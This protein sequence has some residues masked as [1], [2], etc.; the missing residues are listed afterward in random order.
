MAS[1]GIGRPRRMEVIFILAFCI[2]LFLFNRSF[3]LNG[4]N[5]DE[6]SSEIMAFTPQVESVNDNVDL[7]E[8]PSGWIEPHK[9]DAVTIVIVLTAR[10]NFDKR[11]AIRETWAKDKSNVYFVIGDD[12][13]YPPDQRSNQLSCELDPA[14]GELPRIN[15]EYTEQLRLES[16]LILQEQQ[17]F[18]DFIWTPQ[19][20]NYQ[21]LPHKVK[22][23][24]T[25]II[26][27]FPTVQWI[28]KTDDDM[29][30]Q[31]DIAKYYLQSKNAT[32]Y[33]VVGHIV[34]SAKVHKKGKWAE[35]DYQNSQYPS[36]PQG[37]YGHAVSRP[38]AEYIAT[39]K[40][41]LFEYQ[42]EDVSIGIWL[43]ESPYKAH[44][45]WVESSQFARTKTNG[46][47]ARRCEDLDFVVIG[48]DITTDQM[49]ACHEHEVK[50]KAIQSPVVDSWTPP[51][52]TND[53]VVIIVMSARGY[54]DKRKAIRETWAKDHDN[55]YFVI[56]MPCNVS[57]LQRRNELKCEGS[58]GN[59]EYLAKVAME[60]MALIIEQSE[61]R[62]MIYVERPDSYSALVHKL[63]A[64]YGWVL[65]HTRA[66]WVVKVDDDT[67]VRVDYVANLLSRFSP[68][69]PTVVGRIIH[70]SLVHKQGKWADVEYS[71][72]R[73]P[74]WPQG[75]CGY[76]VSRPVVEYVVR[77]S[78]ALFEYQGE[79]TSLGIWLNESPIKGSVIWEKSEAF[80]NEGDCHNLDYVVIGHEIT[81]EK[82]KA[83]YSAGDESFRAAQ[84]LPSKEEYTLDQNTPEGWTSPR[85]TNEKIVIIVMTARSYIDKRQAIRETWA[86]GH[87]NVYFVVSEPCPV[88]PHLKPN[89]LKCE[90]PRGDEKFQQKV[91]DEQK[92]LLAE[93]EQF[94]DMIYTPKPES[95]R[96]LVHKLKI[97][98]L[99][100]LQ[101][102]KAE[103]IIKADDDTF[104]RVSSLG[105]LLSGYSSLEPTVMGRIIQKSAV[106]KQGKW[107]D[108]EYIPFYYPP[109]PQGSCGHVVSRPVAQ[110]VADH[111]QELVE[112]Q[113]EDTTLGIWLDESPLKEKVVWINKEAFANEGNC[114]NST[115]L[116]I[117][118]EIS[119][120]KMRACYETGDEVNNEA[121]NV[122]IADAAQRRLTEEMGQPQP[123][124]WIEPHATKDSIVVLI[125][126][127]RGHKQQR[128]AIRESWASGHDNVYFV[129]EDA[130]PYSVSERNFEWTCEYVSQGKN[131]EEQAILTAQQQ[132]ELLI[133]Q[134]EHLDIIYPDK[135]QSHRGL[136]H[137][138]VMAY[139]WTLTHTKVD[140]IIVAD[141]KILVQVKTMGEW[142]QN[143]SPTVSAHV[144]QILNDHLARQ[145]GKQESDSR[146]LNRPILK[147]ICGH[148]VSRPL[149]QQFVQ[150]DMTVSEYQRNH[151]PLIFWLDQQSSIMETVFWVNDPFLCEESEVSQGFP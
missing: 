150:R 22:E 35:F 26:N 61:F 130:C 13:P 20:D 76:V 29:Y 70:N 59:E 30:A 67:F 66:D 3:Q 91:A 6:Y 17:K 112:H 105:H 98:Y 69:N 86:K 151:T 2:V 140:W 88:P 68:S 56:S 96:A 77:N 42:G 114:H 107:A 9:T 103:W 118:H 49:R 53:T 55:V 85:I 7:K 117:G 144:G 104:V 119:P 24:Y 60:E 100:V 8:P 18:Q 82:M 43:D 50:S 21:S 72:S 5:T 78:D 10:G 108:K 28:V 87:D 111:Q 137:K 31:V 51:R 124:S 45:K 4:Y 57:P 106:H 134:E 58:T 64:A 148:T 123:N 83:C 97:S 33:M 101:N 125:L 146:F 1:I 14:V 74:P 110:Y 63:V 122:A 93:Q 92:T 102:T 34:H 116:V 127:D 115:L 79:D 80:V 27:S 11:S 65:Q 84:T 81:P 36:Y 133:E 48:H 89:E 75:S 99:W 23:A 71:P 141:D 109:W 120:Q 135:Q 52:Q 41:A 38:V 73:Y 16:E 47:V 139:D 32:D 46:G 149:A 121:D 136:L 94:K 62:D 138:L 95:Y 40:D 12:C 25:W 126:S 142:L 19:P 128:Q 132:V 129:I 145:H 113:G 131:K 54:F 90:G 15:A 44:V 143:Y 147:R 39:N 37:S